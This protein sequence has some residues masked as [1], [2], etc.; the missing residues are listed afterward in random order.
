DSRSIGFRMGNLVRKMNL[1]G[2]LTSTIF[3]TGGK[4]ASPVPAWTSDGAI[5]FSSQAYGTAI[6]PA[7]GGEPRVLF[8]AWDPDDIHLG[9]DP[10]PGSKRF[11]FYVGTYTTPRTG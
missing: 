3:D 1:A 9:F 7:G 4:I 2:S 5:L 6:V 8:T 11:L 10:I